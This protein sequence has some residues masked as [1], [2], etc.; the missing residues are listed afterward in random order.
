VRKKP[1]PFGIIAGL[2][3]VAVTGFV[4]LVVAIAL[5]SSDDGAGNAADGRTW[6]DT[7]GEEAQQR[8][9]TDA[10]SGQETL[11]QLIAFDGYTATL[12]KTTG[13]TVDIAV[14]KL[15]KQDNAFILEH[16]RTRIGCILA[17]LRQVL[18]D[19]AKRDIEPPVR[20]G[21]CVG[22]ILPSGPADVAGLRKSDIIASVDGRPCRLGSFSYRDPRKKYTIEV[23]R[24]KE[25]RWWRG[26]SSFV[27]VTWEKH[28]LRI[29]VLPMESPLEIADK[30]A[31]GEDT[32]GTPIGIKLSGS[33]IAVHR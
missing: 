12:R 14:E 31:P 10:A 3:A 2:L 30:A 23:Y 17:D 1:F 11:A 9:W 6:S 8:T 26:G 22:S 33:P 7:P 29:S 4:A 16:P 5:K 20:E 13:K 24:P 21:C 19:Y 15:S 28:N 18:P 25:T 27:T 32:I